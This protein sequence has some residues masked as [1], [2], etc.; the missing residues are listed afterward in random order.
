MS[1]KEQLKAKIT[2][3]EN[4]VKEA[5]ENIQK[6]EQVIEALKDI[7]WDRKSKKESSQ[8]YKVLKDDKTYTQVKSNVGDIKVD[9]D[10]MQKEIKKHLDNPKLRGMISTKEMLSFPKVAK[11]VRADKETRGYTWQVRANDESILVYGSRKY[12]VDE[13]K[14]H[15]LTTAHSKT[16]RNERKVEMGGRSH[17]HHPIFNDFDFR[18]STDKVILTNSKLQSQATQGEQAMDMLRQEYKENS[19]EKDKINKIGKDKSN[20]KSKL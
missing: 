12:V 11:N 7:V 13:D 16:E 10:F 20:T 4:Y 2:E 6:C 14:I 8:M 19:S 18:K 17:P 15:R 5:K 9:K 1:E 3:L